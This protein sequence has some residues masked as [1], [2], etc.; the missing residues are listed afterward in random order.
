[1][2]GEN[3]M[4]KKSIREIT[5]DFSGAD[6]GHGCGRGGPVLPGRPGGADRRHPAGHRPCLRGRSYAGES[7]MENVQREPCPF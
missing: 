3:N 4:E 2:K 6:P 1:M 5:S 7:V